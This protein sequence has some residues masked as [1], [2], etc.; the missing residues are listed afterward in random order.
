MKLNIIVLL[1]INLSLGM[2]LS[3]PYHSLVPLNNSWN[4]ST[5]PLNI[6]LFLLF[7]ASSVN[8]FHKMCKGVLPFI[9]HKLPSAEE[10]SMMV[11][12][13]YSHRS[14][15]LKPCS[16]CPCSGYW[17]ILDIFPLSC[18]YQLPSISSVGP[19]TPPSHH[20]SSCLCIMSV[21]FLSPS[22]WSMVT[23]NNYPWCSR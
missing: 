23:R 5:F 6:F 14:Q 22:F 10:A 8:K 21:D 19:W 18:M 12:L 15:W 11:P 9:L 20:S 2:F 13:C 17:Y 16:L 3:P 1:D 7:T 4:L